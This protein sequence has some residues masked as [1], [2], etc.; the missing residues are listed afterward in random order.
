M[1]PRMT[2]RNK[3]A[4]QKE[5]VL[6]SGSVFGVDHPGKLSMATFRS[7][8]L[9]PGLFF[10]ASVPSFG[11]S[12]RVCFDCSSIARCLCLLLLLVFVV[13]GDRHRLLSGK[14]LL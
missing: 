10:M 5:Y 2:C 1:Q 11:A 7:P 4:L 14:P 12:G 6:L 9:T 3:R 13:V 8:P